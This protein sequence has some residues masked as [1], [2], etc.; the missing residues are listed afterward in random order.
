MDGSPSFRGFHPF[1]LMFQSPMHHQPTR[2]WSLKP[3]VLLGFVLV[4]WPLLAAFLLASRSLDETA[5]LG[6]DMARQIHSQTRT[7]QQVL[8]N[9]SDIERKARLFVLLADPAVRQPY[10]R[11]AYEKVRASF[12]EALDDLLRLS[13]DN[14]IVLLANELSQK[15]ALIHQQLLDWA[16]RSNPTP[17][18]DQAFQGLRETAGA[19]SRQFDQQ[20]DRRMQTLSA[21]TE[22]SKQS[23]SWRIGIL[24]AV[25]LGMLSFVLSWIE[26]SL[27]RQYRAPEV[28]PLT[29]PPGA[30]AL[31]EPPTEPNR[32]V[33]P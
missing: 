27:A 4:A 18:I 10:E 15:E 29:R 17:A 3:R 32:E 2:Y 33:S 16:A 8:E 13:L 1:G 23:L 24:L 7:V 11:A 19:L 12:R 22:D 5:R 21:H 31:D 25:S 30:P 14:S 26:R 9:I 6:L 28:Q 20:V